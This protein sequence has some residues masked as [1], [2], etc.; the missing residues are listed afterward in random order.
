MPSMAEIPL[1][2]SGHYA[3]RASP[4]PRA[5]SFFIGATSS[6][7]EKI[8]NSVSAPRREVPTRP[9]TFFINYMPRSSHN[10]IGYC[11][12]H[13]MACGVLDLHILHCESPKSG[14]IIRHRMNRGFESLCVPPSDSYS[15]V[16]YKFQHSL[17]PP[18]DGIAG[19]NCPS[20]QT[21]GSSLIVVISIEEDRT[22]IA[23]SAVLSDT[24]HENPVIQLL[25][26]RFPFS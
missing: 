25:A 3:R 15:G 6:S 17:R 20:T 7:K 22:G 12:K 1:L 21:N 5:E 8:S 23:L 13:G 14:P 18:L 19:G 11:S 24:R 26:G 9:L 10:I 4:T 16:H 2:C